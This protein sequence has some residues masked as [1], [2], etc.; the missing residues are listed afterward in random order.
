MSCGSPVKDDFYRRPVFKP[1]GIFKLVL[2]FLLYALIKQYCSN[3]S[4][5]DEI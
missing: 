3:Y 4:F 2:L 1:K 5:A